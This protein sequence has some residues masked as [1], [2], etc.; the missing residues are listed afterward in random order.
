VSR[1][2]KVMECAATKAEKM[3]FEANIKIKDA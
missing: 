1:K 2:D 3:K